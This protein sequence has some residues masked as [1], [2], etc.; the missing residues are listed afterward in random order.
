MP[1]STQGNTPLLLLSPQVYKLQPEFS[2]F[3]LAREEFGKNVRQ[4]IPC[5]HF[6]F[7][8]EIKSCTLIP[9]L[10]QDQSTVAQQAEV[11]VARVFPDELSVSSFH[12]CSHTMPAQQH[13]QL[14]P[15][16]LGQG[17]IRV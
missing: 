10:G 9:L 2:G 13:S 16:L 14:T 12:T 11:T 1:L 15:T 17:R 5:L 6:F 3:F 7:K 8:V 4:F